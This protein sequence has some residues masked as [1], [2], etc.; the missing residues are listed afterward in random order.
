MKRMAL[1]I[2]LLAMAL[3]MTGCMAV[4]GDDSQTVEEQ[5]KLS[6]AEPLRLGAGAG[7]GQRRL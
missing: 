5:P 1:Y 4:T 3:S 2:L 7:A 6:A